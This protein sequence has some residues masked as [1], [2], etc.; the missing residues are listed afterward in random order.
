MLMAIC[1]SEATG[2]TE[3]GDLSQVSELR[4]DPAMLVW[5]EVDVADLTETDLAVIAEEFDLHDLAV[6]DALNTRQRPKLETYDTHLFVVMHQLD[7][8]DGQLEGRQV[9]C[10]IGE[11]YVLT[12]H[13]G[14]RRTIDEAKVRWK[15]TL[16][17]TRRGRT[18]LIYT[19][20]D[21][22]VDD[23]QSIADRLESEIEF[24]EETV[25]QTPTA[26]VQKQLYSVKQRLARLRR[27]A[28]PMNRTLDTVVGP[29]RMPLFP[30]ET[31]ALFRDV[32]DHVLRVTD[33]LRNVES[34]AD[35]VLDLQRAEQA[36]ALNEVTKKLTGWAA[37]IAVPTF[38]ASV[39]GMNFELVPNEGRLFGFW[40]ALLLMAGTG[41]GLY[42]FFKR[43]DWL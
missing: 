41:F 20:V 40:F 18:F 43:R 25:L 38:V 9:A 27:Y 28:V 36:H 37:I 32:Y 24:L 23:Y 35:A 3:V 22:V 4:K 42:V 17:D 33:Q 2:W 5:G 6:E 1:H 34:L 10:F 16:P 39:Y 13:D 21:T 15:R 11:G 31:S 26:P 7:E 29:N 8:I 30:E 19:I 14:A 12:V